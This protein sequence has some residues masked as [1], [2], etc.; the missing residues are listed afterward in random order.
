MSE[1]A[2]PS[3]NLT[4]CALPLVLAQV[5]PEDAFQATGFAYDYLQQADEMRRRLSCRATC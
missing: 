4:A 3:S 1:F 2:T 5:E